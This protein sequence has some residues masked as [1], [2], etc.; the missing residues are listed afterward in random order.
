MH[1]LPEIHWDINTPLLELRKSSNFLDCSRKLASH[2][3]HPLKKE[4]IDKLDAIGLKSESESC[5]FGFCKLAA[6][7]TLE[8][9][10]YIYIYI[11]IFRLKENTPRMPVF[12]NQIK[13][14]VSIER[15]VLSTKDFQE[16]WKPLLPA[17]LIWTILLPWSKRISCRVQTLEMYTLIITI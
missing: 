2:R 3:K 16:K 7:Y 10:I 8:T 4:R 11:Y 5:L 12:L 6:I 15:G 9:Y 13:Y 17:F 1:F 14:Y